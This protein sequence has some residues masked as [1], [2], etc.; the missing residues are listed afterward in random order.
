MERLTGLM[1]IAASL[2]LFLL[3]LII[4]TDVV[5]RALFNHPLTGTPELVKVSLVAVVFLQLAHTLRKDRHVRSMIVLCRV[6]PA[7]RLFFEGVANLVGLTLFVLVFY[8]SWPLATAAWEILEYEGEGALRVPTYPV[9]TI[10]LLGSALMALQFGL[11]LRENI[12]E[13]L[14][15][16]QHKGG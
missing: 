14:Q 10:I 3:T 9:R 4:V 15:L 12:K 1:N 6:P 13:G 2:W 8:S 11:F 5:G 16:L 7:V